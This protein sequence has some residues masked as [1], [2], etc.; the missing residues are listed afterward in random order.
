[1]EDNYFENLVGEIKQYIADNLRLS[2]LT[3]EELEEQIEGI[4]QLKT[5]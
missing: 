4:I 1:M 2:E 3:D 5:K